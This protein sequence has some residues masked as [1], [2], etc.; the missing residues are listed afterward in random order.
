MFYNYI[1]YIDIQ[2]YYVKE[3]VINSNIELKYILTDNIIAN[4]LI[5]TLFADKFSKFK[6]LIGLRMLNR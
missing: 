1:K 5:K 2:Y 6:N 3:T 4:K